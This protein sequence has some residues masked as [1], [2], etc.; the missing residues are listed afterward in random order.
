MRRPRFHALTRRAGCIPAVRFRAPPAP[1]AILA[2]TALGCAGDSPGPTGGGDGPAIR[3][4]VVAVGGGEVDGLRATWRARGGSEGESVGIASD[5]TFE[6]RSGR[7]DPRGELLID[8]DAPRAFHPFLYPMHADSISDLV[9]AMVPRRWTI[10]SGE[11]RGQVVD[12]PLDPVVEDDADNY[13]YSY[14]WGQGDP[15]PDPVRYLLDLATWPADRLPARVAFDRQDGATPVSAQDSAAVWSVLDR[16]EAVFGLDLFEPAVADPS[17]WPGPWSGEDPGFV[18]G[19]I[20]VVLDPPTWHGRP[21]GDEAPVAWDE[22]LGAWAS[23]GRFSALRVRHRRLDGG[24]LVVGAFEPLRLSDGFIPWETVLMHEVLHVLGVGH[25]CRI[26]SPQGPCMRTA[27]PSPYDVAY[28]E[29]LR[30]AMRIERE[31]ETFLGIVPAMIGERRVILGLP[32]L[33]TL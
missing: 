23:G 21:L 4:R 5:G 32:A 24:L 18:P 22:E 7:A 33:P 19:V 15:R 10:R 6:I 14:F 16:M 20:R 3:G 26:P 29:L 31:E 2:A 17:W 11:H 9:I 30:E 1:V 8:G 12:T 13:L 27:E 28:M 25:T